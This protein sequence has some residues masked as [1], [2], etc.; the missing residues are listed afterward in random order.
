MPNLLVIAPPEDIN[1]RAF[2]DQAALIE[3]LGGVEAII[4][5][6]GFDFTLVE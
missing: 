6:P 4:N 2:S 3:R 1:D 5:T